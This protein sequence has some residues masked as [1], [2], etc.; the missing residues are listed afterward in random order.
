MFY[1]VEDC[2]KNAKAIKS[3]M[4]SAFNV[5]TLGIIP[6]QKNGKTGR[7]G[8]EK[9]ARNDYRNKPT[10]SRYADIVSMDFRSDSTAVSSSSVMVPE[11]FKTVADSTSFLTKVSDPVENVN[12]LMTIQAQTPRVA[13][14]DALIVKKNEDHEEEKSSLGQENTVSQLQEEVET[15]CATGMVL[16]SG[17]IKRVDE[18]DNDDDDAGYPERVEETK[19]EHE[20]VFAFEYV[21]DLLSDWCYTDKICS[22]YAQGKCKRGPCCCMR[23]RTVGPCPI[24]GCLDTLNNAGTAHLQHHINELKRKAIDVI[25]EEEAK[26][27]IKKH[28][29]PDQLKELVKEIEDHTCWFIPP[30]SAA[31]DESSI[32]SLLSGVAGVRDFFFVDVADHLVIQFETQEELSQ[33]LEALALMD[34]TLKKKQKKPKRS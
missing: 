20:D 27:I 25:G 22:F 34:F 16:D 18:N 12:D 4:S 17:E 10:G 13:P 2:K 32:A 31:T 14:Q 7:K 30:A 8:R 26:K 11:L 15:P 6:P 33:A 19:E 24:P 21:V 28:F 3:S 29:K 9:A 23:H 5:D 1:A